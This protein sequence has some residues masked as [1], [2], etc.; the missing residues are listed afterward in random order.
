MRG[1]QANARSSAFEGSR[2][3]VLALTALTVLALACE[4]APAPPSTSAVRPAPPAPMLTHPAPAPSTDAASALAAK[5]RPVDRQALTRLF[6][7][8][9][10]N[11]SDALIVL[12]NG[13]L[14]EQLPAAPRPI[15]TMSITKSVLALLAACLADRN[16]LTLDRPVVELFPSFGGE[17]QA[18]VRVLHL[19]TH[20]S[21]I[22]EG[23]STRQ[24][25]AS[26]S[27]VEH[28]LGSPI[29]HEP[30]TH[31]EYGNRASN[32][33]A[34]VL[35]RAAGAPLERVAR[36][37]LFE[38]LGITNF[39]WSRDRSG[40]AHGLA[41]LHLLPRDLARLGEL[42]LAEGEWNGRRVLSRELVA[43]VTREPAQLQP[44][45]R[46]LAMLWW[47]VPAWTERTIDSEI[48]AGWKA[49]GVAPELIDQLIPL[50]G[51][52]FRSTMDFIRA[53]RE[54][55]RDPKLAQFEQ[56][57]WK[58]RLPD[59]RHAFGPL[60]G[61]SAQGSLGQWLVIVPEHRLVAVRMRRAPKRAAERTEIDRAF[62]GFPER[63]LGLVGAGR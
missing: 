14:I 45:H 57:V 27:F 51:K 2:R 31:Y 1:N 48:I 41:G 18:R 24:I 55:T 11:G 60:V 50:V 21:G 25:Y 16:Q 3:L 43:R 53:L 17:R 23:S 52:R 44:A 38:P 63:V 28:A 12:Q 32:L 49:G 19:L 62:P 4:R 10:E 33:L 36:S 5:P 42:V 61:T 59:A 46:R 20:S 58:A 56:A 29:V 40:G 13:E 8:A 15:Q 26:R 47:L 35:E 37:C 9:R 22:D 7:E 30:G 34:G 54:R 6:E 39:S